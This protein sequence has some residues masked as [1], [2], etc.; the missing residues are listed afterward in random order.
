M[1]VS[2]SVGVDTHRFVRMGVSMATV[3]ASV[4]VSVGARVDARVGECMVAHVCVSLAY[5]GMGVHS[6]CV[7]TFVY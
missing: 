1:S 5:V 7:C 4:G 2:A 3:D 6:A